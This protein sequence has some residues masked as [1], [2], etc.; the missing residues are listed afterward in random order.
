MTFLPIVERELRVAARKRFTFWSRLVAATL[1]LA[2]FGLLQLLFQSLGSLAGVGRIEFAILK[3]LAFIFAAGAGLFLT[4]DSLSEEIREGTL[5]LLFLTDLRGYDVVFGKLLTQSLRAFYGLLA[6]F[7][8]MAL[9]LLA[10]GLTGAEFWRSLLVICNT[11][12]LSLSLGMLVSSIS[13]DATRAMSG[14]LLFGI[15]IF[16]GAP[17]IDLALAGFGTTTYREIFSLADPAYLFRHSDAYRFPDYWICLLIQNAL[18]WALL[19][20]A[21]LRAPRAW[22]EKTVASAG[23]RPG[24]LQRWRF[25]GPRFRLAHRRRLLAVDP[26]VWLA[27]RDRWLPRLI[28]MLAVVVLL[29]Q[30]ASLVI[31]YRQIPVYAAAVAAATA[32]STNSTASVTVGTYTTTNTTTNTSGANRT[33]RTTSFGY[34]TTTSTAQ[35]AFTLLATTLGRLFRVGLVLWVA[36]QAA[37]FFVDATRNGAMELLLVAPVDAA[38]IV[39]AQW[40]GLCRTYWFP[41]VCVVLLQLAGGVISAMQIQAQTA[42]SA[43]S[44]PRANMSLFMFGEAVFSALTTLAGLA[45][46]AWYGMWMGLTNRKTSVAV[47]KTI[48]FVLVLPWIALIFITAFLSIAFAFARL[49]GSPGLLLLVP[50]IIIGILALGKDWFFIWL[51]R[52]NLRVH[53]REELTRDRSPRS[54]RPD[55]PVPPPASPPAMAPPPLPPPVHAT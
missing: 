8:I 17:M 36:S 39:R 24:L 47:L 21:S 44:S 32:A 38:Q 40:L 19:I 42:A 49:A 31:Q 48:C 14:T 50:T 7:P 16:V 55:A 5:G 23:A 45:A 30:S 25:G 28:W 35:I 1:A 26:L 51:A 27:L 6:A 34:S 12:F 18:A 43:A 29:V 4:S 10:G 15:L 20:L 33:V 3:W 37:R 52:L 46:V 54:R 53:F 2:I 22:Q 41:A 13:R 11:L 9:A